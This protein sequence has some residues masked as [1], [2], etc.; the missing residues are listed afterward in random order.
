MGSEKHS[1]N[2]EWLSEK[3]VI[4]EVLFCKCFTEIYPVIY[5]DGR[6]ISVDGTVPVDKLTALI[7]ECLSPMSL[8]AL[9]G[10]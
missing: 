9:Q 4:N 1:E 6:F 10:V 2:P 5:T 7:G 3:G 8:Q